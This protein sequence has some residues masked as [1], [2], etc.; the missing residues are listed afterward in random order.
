MKNWKLSRKITMGIMLIVI[1]CMSLLYITANKTLKGMMQESERDHMDS[2]L[3]AQTSLIEEYVT[4]Q[5]NLLIA[6]SKTPVVRE[7][8]KD[9]ENKEKLNAAQSYTEY[10]YQGLDNWEGIYIGE[11]NTHCIVH[12]NSDIVGITLREGESL[13]ALQDAMTS[14]NGLYDAGIIVSPVSKK[15]ILSMYCPVFDTDG[16]TILGYVGG[17]P[18][19]EA[20]ENI[21]NELRR[22]GDTAG[23]YMINAETGMYIFADDKSLIATEIQDE[24]LLSIMDKIKAG[25]S[26][27]EMN[28]KGKDG[29]L[30]AS[31]QYIDEHGWAVISFDSEWNIY[32][33]ANKNM[34]VL[35]EICVIFVVVISVLAFFMIYISMKPLQ[36]IEESIIQLSDLKLAK[37]NK[38]APWIG[39]RS[40]IGK[41]ATAINSLYE[42][43]G[44]IVT[45]LSACSSSL[46]D[47][48]VAMQN[49]SDVLISCVADNSKA[50]TA[51]AEHTESIDNT[52]VKVDQEI[53]EIVKVVSAVE[54]QIEQ[55]NIHSGQL[56]DKVGQMQELADTTMENT[57]MQIAENQKAIEEAIDK[58]QTLM[59][60]DEMASKILDITSQTNLLS[61]NASI[62][63][64]RAGEAGRGFAVVA[65]EIGNLANSSSETA[66]QIQSI[67][68]E[69]R[70]NITHIQKCFDQVILFLQND[71]QRQ[72]SEFSNATKDY[73]RSIRDM[74]HIISDI[75]E[76]S[77]I[78]FETVQNIRTQIREVSDVPDDRSV[79]SQDV[80][81]KA[82]QTEETTEAMTVIVSQNKENANAISGIVRRFS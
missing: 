10:Y 72:F 57:N 17:G 82:K 58:L 37:N 15:L 18:Y 78:F 48:A 67:C 81:D 16:T 29:N 2:M 53:A 40:E 60:I 74:Q 52:V 64:A 39:T 42:A 14:R 22:E 8:L 35:G 27:G 76:A 45:T 50:T 4:Q 34:F 49:S 20:L 51:F 13:K 46:N 5:E 70:S 73:C 1:L 59:R 12:N 11:W 9:T 79:S 31:Y 7:L 19:V 75:A 41:I 6:Y 66:T 55:G 63:A 65:G 36:Y 33:S 44:E 21:L 38:L 26:T 3:A 30:I 28:Y 80:L 69:T 25:E 24:M 61:L 62:E 43:L 77:G 54:E 23:Y 32:Y 68:N 47:S 56:L 71:V